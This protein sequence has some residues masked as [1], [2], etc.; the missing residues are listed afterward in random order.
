M[1][2]VA[3]PTDEVERAMQFSRIFDKPSAASF[4]TSGAPASALENFVLCPIA[5]SNQLGGPHW[6][7]ALYQLAYEQAK[8][9]VRPSWYERLLFPCL[10]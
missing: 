9:S 6:T 2:S 10:N 4:P 5:V 3:F 7:V 8:Q 1:K